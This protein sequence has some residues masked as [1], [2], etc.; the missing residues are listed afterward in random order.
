MP[1]KKAYVHTQWPLRFYEQ[2][3]IKKGREK[4]KEK[5]VLLSRKDH[6]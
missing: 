5:R 3:I 2:A 6:V 4:R 1:T